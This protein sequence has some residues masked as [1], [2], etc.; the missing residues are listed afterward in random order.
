MADTKAKA[1]NQA[2]SKYKIKIY[3]DGDSPAECGTIEA[4]FDQLDYRHR[5]WLVKYYTKDGAC[6]QFTDTLGVYRKVSQDIAQVLDAVLVNAKQRDAVDRII[7]DKLLEYLGTDMA[8][9]KDSILDP[10]EP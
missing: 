6:H 1:L 10:C 5:P 7:N 4:H 3:Y 9:E 8:G 2:D